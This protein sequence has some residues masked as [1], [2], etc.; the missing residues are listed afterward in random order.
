M[1][2]LT[3]FFSMHNCRD[4]VEFKAL[5][6]MLS[7]I[8]AERRQ[9]VPS[10]VSKPTP[11]FVITKV[12]VKGFRYGS[13]THLRQKNLLRIVAPSICYIIYRLVLG[14]G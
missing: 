12:F 4:E 3:Q 5:S 13:G 9:T 11:C 10:A 6:L 1:E 2:I 7:S 8:R 14:R